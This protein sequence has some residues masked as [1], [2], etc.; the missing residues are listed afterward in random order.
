MNIKL[1]IS[2]VILCSRERTRSGIQLYRCW[3][4]NIEIHSYINTQYNKT[5]FFGKDISKEKNILF[6][7]KGIINDLF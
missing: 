5:I 6:Y 7:N 2:N 4:V 3:K 1:V